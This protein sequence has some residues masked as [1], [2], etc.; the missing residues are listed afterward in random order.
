M[1]DDLDRAMA[2]MLLETSSS[3]ILDLAR[4]AR[5]ERARMMDE[6]NVSKAQRLS[7]LYNDCVHLYGCALD[8]ESDPE[9][10]RRNS[11]ARLLNTIS[12]V[13]L[14]IQDIRSLEKRGPIDAISTVISTLSDFASASQYLASSKLITEAHYRE[15]MMEMEERLAEHIEASGEDVKERLMALSKM[16]DDLLQEDLPV[17]SKPF[18]PLLI[19]TLIVVMSYSGCR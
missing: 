8:L 18:V 7:L 4:A 2:K 15:N 9:I 6:G 10:V 19:W 12:P 16:M 3:S 14:S 1:S 13:L 11:I 5:I 17:V